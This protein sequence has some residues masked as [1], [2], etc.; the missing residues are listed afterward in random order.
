M[1]SQK[2]YD[3][4]KKYSKRVVWVGDHFQLQP[5]TPKGKSDFQVLKENNLDAELTENHRAGSKHLLEFA[6]F[7]RRGGN[8]SDFECDFESVSIYPMSQHPEYMANEMLRSNVWPVIASTN[9]YCGKFNREIRV[10]M[11]FKQF[12]LE[13]GLRIVCKRNSYKWP[14]INGQTFTIKRVF[15]HE[16]IE[17]ECGKR[18]PVSFSQLDWKSVWIEDGYALTCHKA[19]GSEWSHVAVI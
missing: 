16:N 10:G 15:D 8:P 5:V 4:I 14:A 13:E 9:D 17:T 12:G 3:N 11:G 2:M 18:F 7:V 6:M 19:Q 1:V